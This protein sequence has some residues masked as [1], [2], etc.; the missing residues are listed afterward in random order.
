MCF[1]MDI[2]ISGE[3]DAFLEQNR[4]I[5]GQ[6]E[7]NSREGGTEILLTTDPESPTARKQVDKLARQQ[8][9]RLERQKR[10]EA[11]AERHPI[12]RA[13]VHLFMN[14]SGARVQER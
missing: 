5:I 14:P 6:F 3:F 7:V 2:M 13:A 9:K 1:N 12:A 10:A 4:Q 8:V 11:F